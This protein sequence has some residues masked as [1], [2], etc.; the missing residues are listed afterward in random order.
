MPLVGEYYWGYAS[1]VVAT[2][3]PQVGEFVLAELTQTFDVG[4][5]TYFFPLMAQVE[6]RLGFRPFFGA[7]D[8]AFDALYVYDYFHRPHQ[9]GFAAIPLRQIGQVR[10]FDETGLPLC[11]AGLAMPLKGTF[12]NR[13]SLVQH[14]RGRYVCP[15]LY[16][17]SSGE[18]CPI[19][20]KQWPSGGCKLTMPTS[21][22]ARLRYQL[23]RDSEHYQQVYQQRTAVERLIVSGLSLNP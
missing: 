16:P 22:G 10:E 15:L 23:D 14:Q 8:A 1:G 3:V 4:D 2:R 12:V 17:Q 9:E 11:E 19:H 21:P 20:H 6:Q 5:V 18:C 7:A 13:T